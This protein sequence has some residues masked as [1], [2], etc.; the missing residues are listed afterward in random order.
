M[1]AVVLTAPR[2]MEIRDVPR[3]ELVEGGVILRVQASAICNSTD[4][5]I[6]TAED[7]TRVWPNQPHP[8][9]LGHEIC[10]EVV[11]VGPSVEGWK[12]GDRLAGWC[13][14]LG[15]FAEYCQ[16]F[17]AYLT[18]MHV[19]EAL[20]AEEAALIEPA[21]ATLRY[22]WTDDG[23]AI[24]PGDRVAV[25]GLG[26]AG[27]LYVQYARLLGAEVVAAADHNDRRRELA[28]ALGCE[29]CCAEAAELI[30]LGPFDAVLETT[31]AAIQEELGRMIRPGG[32]LAAFGVGQSYKDTEQVGG[33]EVRMLARAGHE[34]ARAALPTLRQWLVEGRLD[35]GRLISRRIPLEE[36][37]A[38]LERLQQHP[39]DLV[40]VVAV[41]DPRL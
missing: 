21:I 32:T 19:P 16:V 17:P 5:R 10:G 4:W 25:T 38:S 27:L 28:G 7:P 39:K 37:P 33:T 30:E 12:V 31:G 13:C 15:G 8:L 40:K 41:P 34:Q 18:A 23:W 9:I 35:L 36:V 6:Y 29:A 24:C 2:H 22:L 14:G 1:K 20:P 26:P 3:P 11:E